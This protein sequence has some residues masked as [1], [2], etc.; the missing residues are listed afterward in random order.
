MIAFA[1][2][3]TDITD[4]AKSAMVD[5]ASSTVLG[6]VVAVASVETGGGVGLDGVVSIAGAAVLGIRCAGH[7]K[8]YV[9]RFVLSLVKF[10]SEEVGIINEVEGVAFGG[11]RDTFFPIPCDFVPEFTNFASSG[12]EVKF[13]TYNGVVEG[14]SGLEEEEN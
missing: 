13:A 4:V 6:C 12:G 3:G 11:L 9:A 2:I 1:T 10:F 8:S 7:A 5:V 14:L